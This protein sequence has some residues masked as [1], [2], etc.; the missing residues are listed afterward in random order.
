MPRSLPDRSKI[1]RCRLKAESREFVTLSLQQLPDNQLLG[2]GEGLI[3]NGKSKT[4]TPNSDL[5]LQ[6]WFLLSFMA[7]IL[8][9]SVGLELSPT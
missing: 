7:T 4:S 8:F 5:L 3:E 2:P 6:E 1:P 9:A